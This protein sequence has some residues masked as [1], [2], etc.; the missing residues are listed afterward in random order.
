[1]RGLVVLRIAAQQDKNDAE[2]SLH[3]AV[4]DTGIGIPSEKQDVIFHAFEQ[5]DGSTTRKYGGTG[6]GLA[7]ASHLV[8]MMGG[9][10]W[11]DSEVGQGTTFHFT[12]RFALGRPGTG[13]QPRPGLLTGLSALVV[14]D[15]AATREIAEKRLASCHMRGAAP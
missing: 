5:A 9:Q 6:L 12:A 11:V 7:I 15:K 13:C 4:T 2:I 14:D 1:H 10:M 3:F 8:E